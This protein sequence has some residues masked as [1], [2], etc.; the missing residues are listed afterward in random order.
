MS[1]RTTLFATV[2]LPIAV[3]AEFTYRVPFE[4]NDHIGVGIR[5]VVPFGKGK[6]YTG[7][8]TKV[9][10]ETPSGYQ[11]KFIEHLLD[12]ANSRTAQHF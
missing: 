3:R 1:E 4:L 11:A 12:A 7:I 5:V 10:E 6:L 2:I 8:V 9:H